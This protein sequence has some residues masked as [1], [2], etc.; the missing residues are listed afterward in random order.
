ML[1]VFRSMSQ[2]RDPFPGKDIRGEKRTFPHDS[3][4]RELAPH[5]EYVNHGKAIE[6]R[7]DSKLLSSSP[8]S[9]VSLAMASQTSP[10]LQSEISSSESSDQ[11][12]LQTSESDSHLGKKVVSFRVSMSADGNSLSKTT[13]KDNW[14]DRFPDVFIIGFGKSG[15]RALYDALRMHPQVQGGYKEVRYFDSHYNEGLKWYMHQM[16]L[17][18]EGVMIAEKSPGYIIHNNSIARMMQTMEYLQINPQTRKF[19]VMFRDPVTRALSEYVEWQ[20]ARKLKGS[21]LPPFSQL[22]YAKDGKINRSKISFLNTSLYAHH[23]S[24]WLKYFSP[25]QM[26]YVDGEKFVSDPYLAMKSLESC[27][28]LKAFFVRDHFVYVPSRGFFCF[29]QDLAGS[30]N[31]E[32]RSKGRTHPPVSVKVLDDLKRAFQPYNEMLSKITG[33]TYPWAVHGS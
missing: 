11:Q 25:S 22:V 21:S 20:I 15:T 8:S 30:P 4:T 24:N 9:P 23:I 26:C 18:K 29:R 19:V 7:V 1:T 17:P 2:P 3:S 10:S 13:T 28:Q 6:A 5:V 31:C 16:P 32:G 27:L 33:E 12:V 14:K